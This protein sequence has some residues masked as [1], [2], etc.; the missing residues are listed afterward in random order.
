MHIC[1]LLFGFIS[2]SQFL[3]SG[4]LSS[5][6]FLVL[7]VLVSDVIVSDVSSVV[8]SVDN[9]VPFFLVELVDSIERSLDP[10]VSGMGIQDL[11]ARVWLLS[12]SIFYYFLR[13][14]TKKCFTS[15][16]ILWV[17]LQSLLFSSKSFLISLLVFESAWQ[18]L[19]WLPFSILFLV[20]LSEIG[21]YYFRELGPFRSDG[22]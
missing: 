21:V 10:A 6:H 5:S 12:Y 11:S 20:N 9:L 16:R 7:F 14:K 15:L 18:G 4:L 1:S 2:L 22:F 13:K 17:L 19:L 8:V 3:P